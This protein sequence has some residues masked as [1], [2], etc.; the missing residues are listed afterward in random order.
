MVDDL[1]V[2]E[3]DR[4]ARVRDDGGDVAGEEMLAFSD[5]EHER[6]PAPRADEN[7]GNV[8]VNDRDAVGADHLAQRFSNGFDQRGLCLLFR[9]SKATPIRWA[10]TSVSVCD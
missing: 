2:V 4:L 8:R 9:L 6:T 1:V 5:A 7:P 3:V 10:R